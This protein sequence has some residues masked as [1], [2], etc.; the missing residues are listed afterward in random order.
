MSTRLWV[1]TAI[2]ILFPRLGTAESVVTYHNSLTRH[3]AYRM[4]GLTLDAAGKMH[5]DTH[6][7]ASIQGHVYAQPL[8]WQ[9][10]GK[11]SGVIIVATES[12]TVYALDAVSG[13]AVGAVASPYAAQPGVPLV[14]ADSRCVDGG[15]R[16]TLKQDRFTVRDAAAQP[17][18][19]LA[20][21]SAPVSGNAAGS[22]R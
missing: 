18:R 13:K 21:P 11:S 15:Q 7:K 2:L 9:P 20:T 10:A 6:F 22:G 4:P 3:G 12:N 8:Y 16:I 14:I 5:P 19:W 17:Q 1:I